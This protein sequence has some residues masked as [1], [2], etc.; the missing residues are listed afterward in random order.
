MP[1]VDVPVIWEVFADEQLTER[2]RHGWSWAVP[3]FAHSVH[4]DVDGLQPSQ[5]YWYRFRVGREILSPVGR[6]RTFPGLPTRQNACA[7]PGL[8]PEIP[9]WLLHALPAP[10]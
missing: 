3:E 5:T 7:S 9:R 8:L 2:V 6:T 10:G 1:A 4:V